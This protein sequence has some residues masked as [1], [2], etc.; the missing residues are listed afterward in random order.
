MGIAVSLILLFLLSPAV[1]FDHALHR[2]K[3]P[4]TVSAPRWRCQAEERDS[5]ACC[6][7]RASP[8]APRYVPSLTARTVARLTLTVL[9]IALMDR[10]LAS[11]SWMSWICSEFSAGGLPPG[12]SLGRGAFHSGLDPVP[13]GCPLPLGE[14]EE[15]MEHEAGG[16]AVVAGV[17]AFGQ[18]ADVDAL[19]VEP[20]STVLIPSFRFRA[21]RSSLGTMTT[22]PGRSISRS[23]FHAG[24]R[25]VRP[26]ATSVK[27]PVV[28]QAVA[29]EYATLG[30]Q[31]ALSLSLGDPDVAEDCGVHEYLRWWRKTPDFLH[32]C[33]SNA[34]KD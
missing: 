31:A 9:A 28:T 8:L 3:G 10:P 30:G 25:M 18:G 16:G 19:L 15:H 26:E 13:D 21:R 22:S 5:L 14:G 20:P 34:R 32:A 24:R 1:A 29:G 2:F 12:P 11:R 33:L 23:V 7:H 17:Q 27:N 4:P 6:Y